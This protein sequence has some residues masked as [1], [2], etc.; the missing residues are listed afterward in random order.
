MWAKFNDV[1]IDGDEF[2][3]M[4]DIEHESS[5]ESSDNL[6]NVDDISYASNSNYNTWENTTLIMNGSAGKRKY[7]NS[8]QNYQ[9]IQR[10]NTLREITDT[11][12]RSQYKIPI[13]VVRAAAE[14]YYVGVQMH[15]IKRGKVKKGCQ[16]GCLYFMCK[17]YMTPRRPVE[18]AS[19]FNIMQKDV[20]NGMQIINRLYN[21][22]LI[23]NE[24]MKPV[25][26]AIDFNNLDDLY[27]FKQSGIYEK[28]KFQKIYLAECVSMQNFLRRYF[29]ILDLPIGSPPSE[30]F[31]FAN[32][33]AYFTLKFRIAEASIPSSKCAGIIHILS[34]CYPE[35]ITDMQIESCCKISRGTHT[36]F[37]TMIIDILKSTIEEEK[38]IKRKLRRL[39][40]KYKVPLPIMIRDKTTL[41]N[42]LEE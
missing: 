18:I 7:M 5:D 39:F 32:M 29:L 22:G 21:Q 23:P 38:R 26:S 17:E 9:I 6:I 42:Q 33:L 15:H 19:I 24:L 16:A 12:E 2:M 20:S 14:L 1:K 41:K 27:C 13:N 25:V 34:M 28:D 11:V 36:R 10:K 40:K 8:S 3:Q 30:V 37:S 4:M 31:Q 35:S